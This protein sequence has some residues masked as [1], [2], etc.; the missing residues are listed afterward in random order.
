MFTPPKKRTLS[1]MST[2]H[3]LDETGDTTLEFTVTPELVADI[4]SAFAEGD[5]TDEGRY[6]NIDEAHAIA[7]AEVKFNEI[8]ALGYR[9]YMTKSATDTGNDA[10]IV[11]RF[12]D[13][14]QEGAAKVVMQPQ[15]VGG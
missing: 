10:V 3:I 13:V 11:Q 4:E 15:T 7:L 8:K 5:K 2:L 1:L 6:A 14:L 9:T 12:S